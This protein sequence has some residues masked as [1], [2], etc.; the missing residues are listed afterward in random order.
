M[1]SR[2]NT[3]THTRGC[4]CV[5]AGCVFVRERPDGL[6]LMFPDN[7]AE[8]V[9]SMCFTSSYSCKLQ[10]VIQTTCKLQGVIQTTWE[11]LSQQTQL[12]TGI[13]ILYVE[14]HTQAC[15]SHTHTQACLSH[16]HTHTDTNTQASISHTQT[17][18]QAGLTHKNKHTE[19]IRRAK[20]GIRK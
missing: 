6:G 2:R 18:T 3:H 15:L 13:R 8:R 10:G 17:N 19:K 20:A 16:T 4:E 5:T 14:T 12:K 1:Q 9:R 11:R 7:R